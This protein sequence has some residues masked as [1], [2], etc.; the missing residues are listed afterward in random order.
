MGAK[1]QRLVLAILLITIGGAQ[2]ET[3]DEIAVAGMLHG[4]F[5]K[6]G[7]VLSI[8]P[9][10]VS[11][12]HAIADW[13]QGETGGRALLRRKRGEWTVVLCAGDAI[14]SREAL[15]R[16]GVA[17]DDAVRLERDLA[18]SEAKLSPATVA[19]F[20]RFEDWS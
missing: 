19:M 14:K 18:A 20:S 7:M 6:P 15:A 13:S 9:V 17:V 8:A 2:A 4:M 5:D 11:G 12:E 10:V 16:A 3:A 1:L